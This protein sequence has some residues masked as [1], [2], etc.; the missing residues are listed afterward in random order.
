MLFT[1]RADSSELLAVVLELIRLVE[2]VQLTMSPDDPDISLQVMVR[3]PAT[4]SGHFP[5]KPHCGPAVLLPSMG[6][7]KVVLATLH[8]IV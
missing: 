4:I 2:V 8:T 7:Q 6:T 1:E 5:D 3:H